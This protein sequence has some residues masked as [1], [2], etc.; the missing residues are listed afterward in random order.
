MGDVRWE[1]GVMRRGCGWGSGSVDL[2]GW[3]EEGLV[4]GIGRWR[5]LQVIVIVV[6]FSQNFILGYL[7]NI[8]IRRTVIKSHI[9]N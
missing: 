8:Y 9:L 3:M 5:V 7:Y 1:V 6:H 2:R 4:G